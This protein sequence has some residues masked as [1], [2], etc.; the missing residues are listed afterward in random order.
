M[1]LFLGGAVGGHGEGQAPLEA[2]P[3]FHSTLANGGVRVIGLECGDSRR[4]MSGVHDARSCVPSACA[5]F[6]KSEN[7]ATAGVRDPRQI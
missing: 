4:V 3:P 6:Q 2:L 1:A 5:T 7:R